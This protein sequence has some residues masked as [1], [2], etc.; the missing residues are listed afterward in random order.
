MGKANC[1]ENRK[2]SIAIKLNGEAANAVAL[3]AKTF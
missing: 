3:L 2:L 1:E